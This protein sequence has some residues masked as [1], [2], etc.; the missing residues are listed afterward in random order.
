MKQS[1]HYH[2]EH[3]MLLNTKVLFKLLQVSG[4]Y[5][6]DYGFNTNEV[7]KIEVSKGNIHIEIN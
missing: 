4:H 1:R 6:K 7:V 2:E 3:V 5:F